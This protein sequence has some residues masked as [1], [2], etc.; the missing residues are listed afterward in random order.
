MRHALK[1]ALLGATHGDA[2]GHRLPLKQPKRR[3]PN[4]TAVYRKG[5]SGQGAACV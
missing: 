1:T 5:L 3:S 2:A 4:A